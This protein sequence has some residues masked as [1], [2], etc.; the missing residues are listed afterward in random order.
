ML[1]VYSESYKHRTLPIDNCGLVFWYL[2]TDACYD[3]FI[4]FSAFSQIQIKFKNSQK[5]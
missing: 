1:R 4:S 3:Y 5:Q 2:F